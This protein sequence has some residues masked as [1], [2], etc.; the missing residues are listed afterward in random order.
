MSYDTQI[1]RK[2]SSLS[3][4]RK[5]HTPEVSLAIEELPFQ[6]DP[7]QQ[8]V[9]DSPAKQLLLCCSRQWGKTAI[10]ALKALHFAINN[11]KARILIASASLRQASVLLDHIVDYTTVPTRR[12][13][14]LLFPNGS[15]ITALPQAPKTTRG[16]T[17]HVLIIDEAAFV[18]D[19]LFES[20]TP[21]LASTNGY[22][23]VL[24]TAGDQRGFFY[25]IYSNQSPDWH[26]V[27]ATAD[28]CPRITKEYL[29][30]ERVLRGEQRYRR[31]YFCEFQH[32]RIQFTSRE[33]VEACFD[34]SVKEE[35]IHIDYGT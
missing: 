18:D 9:L 24:S 1:P 7:L 3:T 31:E 8:Q 28:D 19:D 33:V 17:A 35:R 13:D 27:K 25:Q 26:I 14:K 5:S 20:L 21:V 10:I 6:P 11:P 34:M 32:G 22:L 16:L 29:A 23:W 15:R 30:R 4:E 2:I 12:G